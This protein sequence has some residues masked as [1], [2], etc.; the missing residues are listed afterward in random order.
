MT[1]P[2]DN[3]CGQPLRAP[4]EESDVG[5]SLAAWTR[6]SVGMHL[7]A[8]RRYRGVVGLTRRLRATAECGVV[9]GCVGAASCRG[10]S[11]HEALCRQEREGLKGV[12]RLSGR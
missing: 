5:A 2:P 9:G 11:G 12:L 6:P 3:R 10:W 8:A 1:A 4:S 7:V